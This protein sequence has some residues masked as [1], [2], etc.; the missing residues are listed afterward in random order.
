NRDAHRIR[1]HGHRWCLHCEVAALVGG[2]EKNG[3]GVGSEIGDGGNEERVAVKVTHGQ[4]ARRGSNSMGY[5]GL[6]GAIAIAEQDAYR[7]IGAV[8]DRNV[9]IAVLVEVTNHGGIGDV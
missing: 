4:R 6:E 3:D 1:T 7:A 8:V 5:L 9:E 2:A